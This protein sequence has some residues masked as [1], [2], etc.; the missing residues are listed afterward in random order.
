MP[1]KEGI[2]D[3]MDMLPDKKEMIMPHDMRKK[4]YNIEIFSIFVPRKRNSLFGIVI[5]W[6]SYY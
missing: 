6:L 3:V 1:K 5:Y 4:P 2:Y